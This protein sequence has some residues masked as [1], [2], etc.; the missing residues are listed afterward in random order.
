LRHISA[1][2]R[3]GETAFITPM[4]GVG[5]LSQSFCRMAAV[6][7]AICILRRQ[8]RGAVIDRVSGRCVSSR[9]A[10]FFPF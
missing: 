6:H 8:L 5:E 2:G 4:Y 9:V 3:F 7:G 10:H 1:L